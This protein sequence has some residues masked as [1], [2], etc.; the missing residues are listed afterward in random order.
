VFVEA[1]DRKPLLEEMAARGASP[2]V[3]ECGPIGGGAGIRAALER[4][5]PREVPPPGPAATNAPAGLAYILYTSGSTG[6][7]KGVMLTHENA[8]CFVRWCSDVFAPRSSD[9]FSSH[10][11]F[12]FDLSIL[13]I[14]LPLR[15]GATLVL[16][17]EDLGKDPVALAA[18]LAERRLTV[19]YSTPSI[20]SM[21]AT[22]GRLERHDLSTL[23]IVLFAGEVFPVRH[24]RRLK[25]LVP[26]PRYFNLYGPTETNVCTYHEIPP[27]IPADRTAPY[28]IG[29]VC[30]HYRARVEDEAGNEAGTGE[31]GELLIS[32]PGVT[33]GYWNLPERDAAVF[34]TTGDGRVWYRTGDVVIDPGDGCFT[35]VGRRD[36]MVKRRGYRVELGEIEAALYRHPDVKEAAVTATSDEEAGV[37]I[38]AFLSPRDGAELS[39]IGMKQFCMGALPAY[40]VPDR[41]DFPPVLPRTSTDKIDYQRLKECP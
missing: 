10:A 14:Y 17:G 31:P 38:R 16:V 11:P 33:R 27:G 39:V 15:H 13:D 25:E 34:R 40:M 2:A 32:G 22:Y 21:L 30:A 37:R 18:F 12:H 26:G 8:A 9:R 28:P 4:K 7:P 6:R 20:L 23:R 41:F 3:L 24:L 19:W 36:R 29:A 35:F 5:E 1:D